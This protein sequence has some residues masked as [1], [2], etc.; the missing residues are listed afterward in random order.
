MNVR[1][2]SAHVSFDTVVTSGS[3]T[4]CAGGDTRNG[5]TPYEF[6]SNG[7]IGGGVV[8][9]DRAADASSLRVGTSRPMP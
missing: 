4:C 1:V 8:I 9:Y 6:G 3:R 2:R 7:A 5:K